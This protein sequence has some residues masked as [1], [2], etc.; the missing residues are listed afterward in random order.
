LVKQ[1]DD[2]NKIIYNPITHAIKYRDFKLYSENK[3]GL[4]FQGEQNGEDN[5]TYNIDL[6]RIYLENILP[7]LEGFDFKGLLNGGIWIEKRKGRLVPTA[8]VQVLDF[9]INGELQG[10]LIGEIR[11]TDSFRDYNVDIF[12]EK[13]DFKTFRTKGLVH[14]AKDKPIL[15][16]DLIFNHYELALFNSLAKGVM[17]KIR[18]DVS[19]VVKLKGA[20]E[21]PDF[22]GSLHTYDAGVYFPYLNVDYS[23][24]NQT[25]ITLDRRSF[26]F[27]QANIKDSYLG[28][29][30]ILNG[31]ITH[32][33][34]KKWFLDIQVSTDN[35][36]AINTEE[37]EWLKA[38]TK[39]I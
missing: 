32:Y 33:Y 12:I 3:G 28:T 15:D 5:Q 24:E 13:N 25:T 10:D 18:G 34:F 39:T 7:D 14:I 20:L 8:D 31:S 4:L 38:K 36:L 11:G 6:D 1:A 23:L 2:H 30:G 26:N 22:S 17:E 37:K 35:L 21:N 19:G 27:H 9:Y 29:G 16:V